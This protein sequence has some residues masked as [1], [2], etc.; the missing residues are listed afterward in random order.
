[1][2][3]Q[4]G[5]N[6][7]EKVQFKRDDEKQAPTDDVADVLRRDSAATSLTSLICW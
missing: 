7:E 3:S 2:N 6:F 4:A 5:E 1:L